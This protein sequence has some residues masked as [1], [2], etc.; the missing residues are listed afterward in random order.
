MSSCARTIWRMSQ[1]QLSD[2]IELARGAGEILRSGYGQRQTITHKGRI[3]LVTEYDRRSEAWMLEQLKARFPG[4]SI[5]AEESGKQTGSAESLWLIDPLDGTT[6]YAHGLP[7]FAVSIAYRFAGALTLGVVY[8]PIHDELYSAELGQGAQLNGKP[9]HCSDQATLLNS[10]LATGF[11]YDDWII[12]TNLEHFVHF[13]KL[14]QGVRRL[15]SAALDLCYVGAGRLDGYWEIALQPY[16]SAAGG[17]IAREA[18]A[19]VSA[20]D[21]DADFQKP[22]CGVLAANPQLYP[23]LLAGLNRAQR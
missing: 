6:N 15:G 17:L 8:N 22:P 16:D 20:I 11:A 5:H 18:G 3:D 13:S 1:P 9:I 21:G 23:Q 12:H 7:I 2:L 4:H 19:V 14:T 10:M